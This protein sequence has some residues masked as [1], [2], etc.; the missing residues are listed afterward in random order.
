MLYSKGFWVYQRTIRKQT[1]LF[2]YNLELSVFPLIF[3]SHSAQVTSR[4][5]TKLCRVKS[6]VAKDQDLRIILFISS[7][8]LPKVNGACD[9]HRVGVVYPHSI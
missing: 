2:L 6:L 1:E 7:D 5:L 4:V 9:V 8:Q 3:H